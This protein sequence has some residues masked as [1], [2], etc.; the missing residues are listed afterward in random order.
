MKLILTLTMLLSSN[1]LFA[2][3]A[4]E[5]RFGDGSSS[6]RIT[7]GNDNSNGRELVKRIKRLERAVGHLQMR[8]YELEDGNYG[9]QK[10]ICSVTTCRKSSS[11]HASNERNCEFFDLYKKEKVTVWA[12]SGRDAESISLQKLRSDR[13]I[14]VI[15]KST[16]NCFMP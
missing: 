2:R 11:V 5:I 10:F 7:V 3:T 6:V 16:L 1:L 13:D 15:K 4:G 8:V 14:L 9:E 12:E